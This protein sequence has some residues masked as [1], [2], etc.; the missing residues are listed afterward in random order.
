MNPHFELND[1]TKKLPKHLHKFIVKQPYNEYTAQNQAVWRYVM[2]MNV[3]Y[4]GKVAHSSYL[5]GLEKTGI[6]INNIPYMEGMNRILKEIGWSAVSVDGF[7][8][9]N[10]FMEFQAYNVLVIASDIRTINHIEYTPAP[11]IIHEA[12]GHAPI[13]A[14]PEYAEYLRR[15]GEIGSKAISSSKDYEMYEAIR[16]LSIL[17]EDPNATKKSI[18]DAQEKVTWLQDNMGELSEMAQIRNLHWWTV[19]YGLIGTPENPK[20]Y[21]AGLL[22]SIGESKWCMQ[23][24]VKKVPYSVAAATQ[25]FDITKP[26]PQLFVTPNFAYLSLVLNEFANTMALRTG[27]LKG[28]E[29]LINSKNLGTV[30]LSTGIQIS[31]MFSNV[32]ED[33]KGEIAYIQTTG[34]TALSNR[35]KELIGHGISYHAQGFGSPVGKL[36]G[37]NLP[38][39][40][41]SPRDLEA[42]GIYEGEIINLEFE[43]GVLVTGKII[44]GT[45]DLRGKILIVSLK[46]CRVTYKEQILFDPSWGIY[47]M[48]IGKELVSAY[49]G[50]A[51]VDS[52]G[53][54]GKVSETK[55]H[56]IQYS[57]ADNTL[58]QMYADVR[59]YRK[60]DTIT[61]NII[62]RIL[63]VLKNEYPKDWLLVL[64]L[65][66]LAFTNDFSIKI[67]LKKYLESLKSNKGYKALIENGLYLLSEK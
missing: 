67:S 46:D 14:N 32:I 16:L 61:E 48:A 18:D 54:I 11:D 63:K 57:V 49:S 65:Y 1:V 29:K 56:K 26:Q 51:D 55:T 52:F 43:S 41:M 34:N 27:G 59:K 12:A 37:I 17:K 7:I 6:S 25:N 40:D 35:D 39:E 13:I 10:A 58:Y 9:P 38:I 28:V 66:E 23:S 20:I 15:F 19:E 5:K 47:D 50:P 8:P 60:E 3:D 45:R 4:L 36:K 62:E 31:G 22:S 33:K 24:E 64:E 21:G 2:R 42:Y 44:T 30:E 53:D